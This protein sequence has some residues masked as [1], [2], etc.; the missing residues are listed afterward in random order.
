MALCVIEDVPSV[1]DHP[2][3]QQTQ[4]ATGGTKT[5]LEHARWCE[6]GVKHGLTESQETTNTKIESADAV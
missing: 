2:Y 1:P 5:F 6:H 4:L 3:N